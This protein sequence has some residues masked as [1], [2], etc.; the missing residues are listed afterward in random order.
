MKNYLLN[1]V[2]FIFCGLILTA[3]SSPPYQK[4]TPDGLHTLGVGYHDEKIGPNTYKVQYTGSMDDDQSK[5]S[6]LLCQRV[7]EVA[8]ENC[9]DGYMISDNNAFIWNLTRGPATLG[10]C[11]RETAIVTCDN[12]GESHTWKEALKTAFP[13]A[14]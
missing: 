13:G 9:E 4:A 7:K 2:C 6:E 5:V 8:K 12:V 11:W 1:R 10:T 14:Y 3:C